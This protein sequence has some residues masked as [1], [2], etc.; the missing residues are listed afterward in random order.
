MMRRGVQGLLR[1]GSGGTDGVV[2]RRSLE[3][4]LLRGGRR[5]EWCHGPEHEPRLPRRQQL[6]TG[7][8]STERRARSLAGKSAEALAAEVA[9]VAGCFTRHA[10]SSSLKVV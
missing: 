4:W 3:V 6:S 5:C 2:T 9:I 8:D 1:E 7:R 10:Q